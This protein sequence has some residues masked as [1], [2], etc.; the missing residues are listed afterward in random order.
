MSVKLAD[1]T[2]RNTEVLLTSVNVELCS[3]I[4]PIEFIIFPDALYNETLLGIDFITKAQLVVDFSNMTWFTA[5]SPQDIHPLSCEIPRKPISCASINLLRDDEGRYLSESERMRLADVLCEYADIFEE[6]GEPTPFAEHRIDT[7]DHPPIAVPPYRLT[8]AKKEIM[9]AELDQM[10][11]ADVIE[12]CES[13]W[14]A[15]CVLVPKSNGTYRFCVDYRKLNV[16]TKT[17]S[18]PMPRI[19]ELLQFTNKGCVMTSLDLRNGYWQVM[20]LDRDKTAFVTPFGTYRFKRMPFGLKNAPATFQRLIDRFRA[21][22]SLQDVTILAY[23]DDLLVIS[24]SFDKHLLDL[25]AVFD[26][27]RVFKLRANRDKRSFTREQVKY[28]GHVI[29]QEGIS[30]DDDKVRAVLDMKEPNNLQQLRTFLQT[31]SWFRKF[32]PD[33]ARVSEPL[34]RLTRKSQ[35]W[36]WGSDQAGAFKSL[37]ELLTTAPI[38]IQPDYSKPFIL[39]T[40]ASNFALGACLLQGESPPDERP[41]EYA[42]RL[43][44]PA[45]RNYSTTERE[46]LAVVWAVERFRG[47]IDG[48]QVCVRSD[49]QPLKWLFSV[50]SPSGRLVRW[51]LKLQAYN[52]QIEYTPGKANV[53]ADTLSRPVIGSDASSDCE[54]CPV[55]VD[56]PHWDAT[57]TRDAQMSDPEVSKI[58]TDLEGT[59]ELSIS[60]WSERGYFLAQG[61]LYRYSEDSESE[62]PQLVIPASLRSKVMF[63]CHDSPTAAHGGIQRTIHRISQRFYFPGLRRYVTEY[64]KTCIECQRY[65][66]SNLKPAGLLQTPVPA[67]RFEIIA[68]DL[69]GPLPKGPQGERWI[70]IVEDLASKWVEL[71]ALTEATAEVCAKTLVDE[72]FMRYGLPRRM[73]SDNGVQFVADVMQKA[74][75]VLGVKQNLIPLYHPESNPV[76]RKNRDLKAHLAILVEGRHQQWPEVLSFIRFAFNSSV[77]SSTAHTPAY[78]TFGRELRSPLSAQTDLRVVVESENFVPQI[79]PYLLKLADTIS[80]TKEHIEHHQELSLREILS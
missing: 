27:L 21:G 20:T 52:L 3:L 66:A 54:V 53:I 43:L 51:A 31:C 55:S 47:Y 16:V 80:D 11:A 68:V 60:R 23:L 44:T 6:V 49:H 28:L 67:Q 59:D 45:E 35:T 1:G 24:D 46:A 65:K 14:S 64:L 70:L 34:T 75:F 7:G 32:I 38:L 57:T 29:S 77:C 63:E 62:E 71:F 2:V 13:A 42:S 61:V 40:D 4:V 39:R 72:V 76:E 33:F 41:I 50:K 26:R 30:P 9:R 79:T 5:K 36:I 74:M 12:E 18:Y 56:V 37:K 73:I 10:L 19:D 69:F 8:P 48:H 17:D 15:P 58:I 25:R 78:L 22:A